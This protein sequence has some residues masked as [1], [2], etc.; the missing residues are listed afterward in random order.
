MTLQQLEYIIALDIE[1]NFVR[2]AE[3]SF[4]TQ[5][6]ITLQIQKLENELGVILFDRSKKPLIPTEIGQKVL[7]QARAALRE[8][9][10]IHDLVSDYNEKPAGLIRLGI[11]P[12]IAPYLLPLFINDFI[13]KHPAISVQVSEAQTET[14]VRQLEDDEIDAAI[15]ATPVEAKNLRAKILFF[16]EMRVFVSREHPFYKLK[17]I[18]PQALTVNELWLLSMGNCFRNQV[19]TICSH[20]QK[21][22]RESFRYESE[23]IES[24]KRIVTLQ[25]GL[26]VIPELATMQLTEAEQTMVKKFDG[27]PPVREISLV[28]NRVYLK[29]RLID[30][31]FESILSAVPQNMRNLG[32]REL[33]EPF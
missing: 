25:K 2:A 28:L 27:I 4:I 8:A 6:G 26:T 10:R 17:S 14:L 23:S 16:E 32:K 31:L 5:P 12:T 3:R 7:E 13:Q 15:F 1:R 29:K 11:L 30:T 24:L 18:A 33:V 19:V 22:G 21:E 9:K 20:A